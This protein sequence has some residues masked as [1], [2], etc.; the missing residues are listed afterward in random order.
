MNAYAYTGPN[1]SST[2]KYSNLNFQYASTPAMSV[3]YGSNYGTNPKYMRIDVTNFI[4]LCKTNPQ[5]YS[6]YKG[7]LLINSMASKV[8]NIPE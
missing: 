8:R 7:I 2:S 4:N 6:M 5:T 1:W 3:Q